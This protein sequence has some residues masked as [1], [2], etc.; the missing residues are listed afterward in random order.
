MVASAETLFPEP[1]SPTT[2]RHSPFPIE[3]ETFS[4]TLITPAAVLNEMLRSLTSITGAPL[5]PLTCD[6]EGRAL[7]AG[8]RRSY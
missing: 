3:K 2:A 5:V 8:C 4:T 7:S 1:D 6:L